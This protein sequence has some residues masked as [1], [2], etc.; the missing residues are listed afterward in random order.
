MD[1]TMTGGMADHQL[2]QSVLLV[3]TLPVMPFEVLLARAH[4]SA[5]G[6]PPVRLAQDLSPKRRSR[7]QRQVAV[8]RVKVCRPGRVKGGGG[9]FDLAV[10]R[11]LDRLPTPDERFSGHR[12]RE[13]PGFPRVLGKVASDA[14]APGWVRVASLGPSR[15]P[16]PENVGERGERRATADMAVLVRPPP[17]PGVEGLEALGRGMPRGLL[18]KRFDPRLEGL[19]ADRAGRNRQRAQLAVGSRIVAARL[20]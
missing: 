4:L 19:E 18:T 17:P 8:T 16:P 13:P 5:D 14:P 6:A 11:R 3:M 2:R 20:P 12:I 1:L 9:A 7:L 15:A 10:A